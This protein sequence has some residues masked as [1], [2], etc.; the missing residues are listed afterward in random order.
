MIDFLQALITIFA[1]GIAWSTTFWYFRAEH[2]LKSDILLIWG[3]AAVGILV[4][5]ATFLL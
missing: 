5:A 2:S 4:A 1:I 3:Y